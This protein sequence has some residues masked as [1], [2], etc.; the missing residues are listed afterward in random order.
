MNIIAVIGSYSDIGKGIFVSS[1]AYILNEAGI[2]T[3]PIKF[4]GY[5][6]YNSGSMNPYHK[7]MDS[8]YSEEEV[9]VL[10]DGFEG[11]ADSGYYERFTGREFTQN[12][13]LTNGMIFHNLARLEELGGK[14]EILKFLHLRI[15]IKKWLKMNSKN[16]DLIIVEIGGTINDCE[17][18]IIFQTLS[19][20]KES[21]LAKIFTIM[22]SPYLKVSGKKSNLELSSR[23]KITR[24][25]FDNAWRLGL[26]PNMIV[27]RTDSSSNVLDRD[28]FYISKDTSLLQHNILIEPDFDVI[29]KIPQYIKKQGI[30]MAIT[31]F[32]KIRKHRRR[33]TFRLEDYSKKFLFLRNQKKRIRVGIYGKT[34]SCDSYI[35]LI[36]AVQ[37][38]GITN[39]IFPEIVWLEDIE[40]IG[41]AKIDCLIVSEGI[42]DVGR[43]LKVL[44]W[45]KERNLPTL[46]IGFGA[47]LMVM[48]H[49]KS[50]RVPISHPELDNK[51]QKVFNL[52]GRLILG[53]KNIDVLNSN[54]FLTK[55]GK[56]RFRILT[57]I[58]KQG[59]AHMKRYGL[60]VQALNSEIGPVAWS[61][62]SHSMYVGVKF[63]P[64]FRSFPGSCHPLLKKL[65]S[66]AKNKIN[67]NLKTNEKD[68]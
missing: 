47:D 12:S 33:Q 44:S 27:L 9:F 36:E 2:K 30:T 16:N 20:L 39:N 58:T 60:I 8:L 55:E 52:S 1:L 14:G 26:R 32:F 25:G 23:S 41:D 50:R 43:K 68:E 24:M 29:Y 57:T 45:A 56:E 59:V 5:L 11:D 28:R 46:A 42:H 22:L 37:H 31:R 61:L 17:N 38:A 63:K 40:N 35:S 18:Q 10:K 51:K 21:G 64:E 4:D 34:P 19:E 6:N 15:E 53:E 66:I 13:N 67:K 62:P 3:T 7:V 49:L 48:E 54:N 65:I